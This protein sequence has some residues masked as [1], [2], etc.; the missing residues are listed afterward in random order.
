MQIK[1]NQAT[2]NR[3]DGDRIIDAP[4][5]LVDIQHYIEQLKEE[6]AWQKS[7]RNAITVFKTPGVTV[8]INA[9][10]SGAEMSDIEIEGMLVLQVV[11]GE[12]TIMSDEGE[13][14][15]TE[16]QVLILHPC[17]KTNILAERDTILILSN[18]Q[19]GDQRVKDPEAVL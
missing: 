8:V 5:V 3:P 11:E 4:A 17:F 10:H 7:D 2:N 6:D 9:L 18:I 14:K 19:V 16:Q 1:I 13:R 15:L 12:I